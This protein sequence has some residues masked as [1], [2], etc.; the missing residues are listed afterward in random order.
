VGT[1]KIDLRLLDANLKV[2]GN[3]SFSFAGQRGDVV[4]NSASFSFVDTNTILKADMDGDAIADIEI[5][6]V[7]Q[8]QLTINDF[9]GVEA[10]AA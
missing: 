10:L 9:L 7:G 4:S 2:A 8:K 5:V 1:D 6:L 3:Q